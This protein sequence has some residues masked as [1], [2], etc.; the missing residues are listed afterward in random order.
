MAVILNT[1]EGMKVENGCQLAKKRD[2]EK[3]GSCIVHT[4]GQ[5]GHNQSHQGFQGIPKDKKYLQKRAKNSYFSKEL[6]RALSQLDSPLNKAYKRTLFDCCST[7]MQEGVSLTSKYCD[8]RWCNTCN[9]IRTARLMNGYLKP[10]EGMVEPYFVTLTVPNVIKSDLKHTIVG[11]AR[12]FSNILKAN[13]R[14]G[15]GSKR[16]LN[17]I[18]KLECTYNDISDNYHPHFHIIVDGRQEAETLLNDWL[19]RYPDADVRGQDCRPADANGIKELFKYTTKIVSKSKE[20]ADGFR[21]IIPA[22]DVIFRAMFKMRTFQ[23]FG[24]IRMVSEDIEGIEKE[25]YKIAPYEFMVWQWV[26]NDW[27]S[28]ATGEMLTGYVPSK[29]IV[30]LLTEKMVT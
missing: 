22:L 27:Q 30:E 4:L 6:A 9:R 12:T 14:A 5:V 16:A 1:N 24:N 11:M 15:N 29:R 7:L 10:L 20:T 23:S 17:G 28:M 3:G 19:S 8:S 21:I 25:D 26:G 18:R 13:R 2:R